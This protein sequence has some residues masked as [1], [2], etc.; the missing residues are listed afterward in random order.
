MVRY[1]G[2][3]AHRTSFLCIST[4]GADSEVRSVAV[5]MGTRGRSSGMITAVGS[6]TGAQAEM[7]IAPEVTHNVRRSWVQRAQPGVQNSD[8]RFQQLMWI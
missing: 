2:H 6:C 3:L 5:Q 4:C 1:S 7:R 8:E